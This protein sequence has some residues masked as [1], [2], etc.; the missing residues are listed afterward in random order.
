MRNVMVSL[1]CWLLCMG[2][3]GCEQ[4]PGQEEDLPKPRC[5]P[6]ES[7]A[8]GCLGLPGADPAIDDRTYPVG[9]AVVAREPGTECGIATMVCLRTFD[10]AQPIWT[11]GL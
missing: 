10:G 3:V 11:R 6:A 1:S 8:D 4:C 5:A 2:V 7:G 9:C